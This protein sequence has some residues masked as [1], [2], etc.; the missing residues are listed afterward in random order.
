MITEAVFRLAS[1]SLGFE[2]ST[3]AHGAEHECHEHQQF[4]E[5][6]HT[7]RVTVDGDE[8]EHGDPFTG[9]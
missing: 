6:H 7:A 1:R 2:R 5:V 9:R 4:H 8:A 3:A